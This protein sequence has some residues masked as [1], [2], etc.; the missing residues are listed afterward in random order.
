MRKAFKYRLYPTEQQD[1]ALAE[2]LDTHRHLYNR[3]LAERKTAWDERQQ[4]VSYGKQSAHVKD[5]RTTNPF[6]A[7][8]NFSS[9]Q[10]TLRRLD[11]SFQVFFRRLQA[12]ETPGYPRFKGR[13][14]FDTVEF[15]AYGDGCKLSG[16]LVYFQHIGQV[17]IKLHRPVEGTIKTIKRESAKPM[18]GMSSFPVNCPILRSSRLRYQPPGLILASKPSW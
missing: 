13:N 11:R 10:A 9:C 7:R 2:M 6:L 14:R 5:E 17:K 3:A 18:V 16:S 12:G 8:T 15:P 1:Q 4:S